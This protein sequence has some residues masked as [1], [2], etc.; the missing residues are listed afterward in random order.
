MDEDVYKNLIS[1]II[2][3]RSEGIGLALHGYLC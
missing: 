2:S 3:G 1:T